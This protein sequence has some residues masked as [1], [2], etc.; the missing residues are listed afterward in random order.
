M[1][2][3]DETVK[4]IRDNARAVI[5]QLDLENVASAFGELVYTGSYSLD[6]MTWNDI[7]MQLLLKEGIDAM[8]ALIDILR[9]IASSPH[10]IRST[11]IHCRGEVKPQMPRGVYLGCQLDFPNL[12]GKWKLDLWCL[13]SDDFDRNRLLLE[14]IRSELTPEK[15]Q[16]ILKM[17]NELQR[18]EGRV[19]QMGSHLLYEAVVFKG[20]TSRE[21]LL[22]YLRERGV[23][24]N[25]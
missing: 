25:D 8:P 23:A 3:T 2:P 15:R 18:K 17:K 9:Q 24:I 7:D 5:E 21:A 16:L 14:K 11:I 6:L 1:K 4:R 19:P 20:L 12:G 10:F 13:S 22:A